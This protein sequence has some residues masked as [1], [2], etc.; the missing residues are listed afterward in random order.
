MNE[1][2]RKKIVN[3]HSLLDVVEKLR[4]EGKRIVQCH[5]CFDIV[6]PGHIRHLS[7]AADQ[8]DILIVSVTSDRQVDKGI[9]RPVVPEEL[10]CESLA[11][12]A[13]VDYVLVDSESWAGPLLDKIRP[14]VYV[15]GLEY[16]TN[17]DPRFLREKQ[18]VEDYGG[19]VVYTSGEVVYSSSRLHQEYLGGDE[20]VAARLQSLLDRHGIDLPSSLARVQSF[21]G[22][23]LVVV[24]DVLLDQYVECELGGIASDAPVMQVSPIDEGCSYVGGAGVLALHAANLG[25]NVTY[26]GFL[27]PRDAT[28]NPGIRQPLEQAGVHVVS[29]PAEGVLRKT[30]YLVEGQKVFKVDHCR[31]LSISSAQEHEWLSLLESVFDRSPDGMIAVDFGYGSLNGPR[32]KAAVAM[33]KQRDIKAFADTSSNRYASL[34]KFTGLGCDAVFPS[35]AEVRAYLGEPAAGLPVLVSDLFDNQVAHAVAMTLGPRGAVVFERQQRSANAEGGYRYLPEYLPSLAR[36]PLDPLGAGDALTTVASMAVLRGAS[37]VEAVFLGSV[38]A[39][40]V[41]ERLGNEPLTAD[42]VTRFLKSRALFHN[43]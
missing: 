32:T 17:N 40:V 14:D 34:G 38:A 39:A 18:I 7:D 9:G 3:L 42:L 29:V 10:R 31:P 27:P 6:H 35:E 5:G 8:G 28:E 23:K 25:A 26:V 33:A 13:M 22:L 36:F 2:I 1:Q 41:V 24:G 43:S 12:L 11:A 30:R 37:F 4:A 15:K 19:V 20:F 16:S 21:V